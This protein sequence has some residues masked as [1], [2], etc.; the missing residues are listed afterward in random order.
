[1]KMRKFAATI[2]ALALLVVPHL[3]AQ[4]L[5]LKVDVEK[6]FAEQGFFF[7]DYGN[8]GLNTDRNDP[9][10][11]D[12]QRLAYL[13]DVVTGERIT[14]VRVNEEYVLHCILVNDGP[15]EEAL[16]N[17]KILIGQSDYYDFLSLN[18]VVTY[19]DREGDSHG[20]VEFFSQY[21]VI[22]RSDDP[23]A[24]GRA[25]FKPVGKAKLYNGGL[26][27]GAQVNHRS[28]FSHPDTHG[29]YVGYD[30]QDGTLPYGKEYACE[31]RV[32][33]RLEADN[34]WFWSDPIYNGQYTGRTIEDGQLI[35]ITE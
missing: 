5:A 31:I 35:D 11:G 27:N 12:E 16:E 30:D 22:D 1:M 26:L 3:N 13:T 34:S 33:V 20:S 28:L 14:E 23:A 9:D 6:A 24:D 29:I 17:V 2:S 19:D 18:A 21:P 8:G 7:C 25:R 15:T 32:R 4:A 10:L